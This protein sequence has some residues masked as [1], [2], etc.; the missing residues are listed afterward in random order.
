MFLSLLEAKSKT[1][2]LAGTIAGK[3]LFLIHKKW[4]TVTINDRRDEWCLRGLSDKGVNS[5]LDKN[6]TLTEMGII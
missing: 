4:F 1:Q 2:A 5:C 6:T 3:A